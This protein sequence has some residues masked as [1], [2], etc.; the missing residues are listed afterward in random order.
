M[1]GFNGTSES[2]FPNTIDDC[3]DGNQGHYHKHGSIDR[4]AVKTINGGHFKEG[5]RLLIEAVVYTRMKHSYAADFYY[6]SDANNPSWVYIGE[7]SASN[8][9]GS[10]V[11]SMEHTL[12]LPGSLQA[13]RVNLRLGERVSGST[14]SG[15]EKDDIDDIVF[16]VSRCQEAGEHWFEAEGC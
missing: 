16:A 1:V 12:F 3:E 8:E 5:S 14:C 10:K 7:M 6:A 11:L 15:G 2:H 9:G 13:I 4:L